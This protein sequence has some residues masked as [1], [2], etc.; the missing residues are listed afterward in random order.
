MFCHAGRRDPLRYVMRCHVLHTQNAY[1]VA[2]SGI[3]SGYS[4][5]FSE[6]LIF[7]MGLPCNPSSFCS[8]RHPASRSGGTLLRAYPAR[9]RLCRRGRAFR[10]GANRAPDCAR[11]ASTGRRAHVSRPFRGIFFRASAKQERSRL[12]M[13]PSSSGPIQLFYI[14]CQVIL[15]IISVDKN[16]VLLVTS[17]VPFSSL[18]ATVCTYLI[19]ACLRRACCPCGAGLRSLPS[20]PRR[21]GPVPG[22]GC[23]AER[24]ELKR[25][26]RYAPPPQPAKRMPDR[27]GAPPPPAF[28][29]AGGWGHAM[30]RHHTEMCES[31]SPQEE[32]FLPPSVA[33]CCRSSASD[34]PFRCRKDAPMT[35]FRIACPAFVPSFAAG[36]CLQGNR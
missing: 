25:W 22:P 24:G 29:R 1:V 35:R 4:I 17:F 30:Q 20:S 11:E 33:R 36:S 28:A 9:G 12:R 26:R 2:R 21:R 16:N 19:P 6:F 32:G 23:R 8:S 7:G 13:A 3:G 10:G 18:P 27:R 5:P 34:I 15:R 31:G 14:M